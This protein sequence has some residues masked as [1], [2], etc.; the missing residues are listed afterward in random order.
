V[1]KLNKSDD[2]IH[3]EGGDNGFSFPKENNFVAI[4]NRSRL[5]FDRQGGAFCQNSVG[6]HISLTL[7]DTGQ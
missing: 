2:F 7:V 3:V 6:F 5:C 4:S 1:F